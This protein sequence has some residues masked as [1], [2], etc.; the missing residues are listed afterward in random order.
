MIFIIFRYTIHWFVCNK[1]LQYEYYVYMTDISAW[2]SRT[3][4][5]LLSQVDVNNE[6]DIVYIRSLALRSI[7]Q[8]ITHAARDN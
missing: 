8:S 5:I 3:D 7:L 4:E 1:T 6:N 2:H